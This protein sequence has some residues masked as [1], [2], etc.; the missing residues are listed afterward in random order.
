[1]FLSSVI[2]LTQTRMGIAWTG[3]VNQGFHVCINLLVN[4]SKSLLQQGNRMLIII[5]C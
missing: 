5:I 2:E 1:M 4:L 3:G